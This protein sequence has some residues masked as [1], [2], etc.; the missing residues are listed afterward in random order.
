MAETLNGLRVPTSRCRPVTSESY[1]SSH[2]ACFLVLRVLD[3]VSSTNGIIRTRALYWPNSATCR[4]K[5][6]ILRT[7]SCCRAPTCYGS[8]ATTSLEN[9]GLAV[10]V[11]P[12]YLYGLSNCHWALVNKGLL[13]IASFLQQWTT[14][15]NFP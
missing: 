3:F 10:R 8:S 14:S 7:P 15:L 2:W 12:R 1:L 6:F 5:T 4:T 13:P 9:K 11:S